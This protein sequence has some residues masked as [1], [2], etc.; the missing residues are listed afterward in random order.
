M[1]RTHQMGPNPVHMHRLPTKLTQPRTATMERLHRNRQTPVARLAGE[2][3]PAP[4]GPR[5]GSRNGATMRRRPFVD[6]ARVGVHDDIARSAVVRWR[7]VEFALQ[8]REVA[9]AGEAEKSSITGG[10]E[11][12]LRTG[13]GRFFQTMGDARE[14]FWFANHVE[15]HIA[16]LT[17]PGGAGV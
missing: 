12:S 16:G 17:V 1:F 6:V 7:D 9:T 14:V 11:G 13:G 8:D 2:P 15:D 5:C 4:Y 3:L 10:R